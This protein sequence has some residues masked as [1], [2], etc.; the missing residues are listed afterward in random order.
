MKPQISP[1]RYA[2]VEMTNLFV[3]EELSSR[4]ERTRISCHAALETTA[5]AAFGK[6]S[7]MKLANATNTNRKSGAA[8]WRDLR[9]FST[10]PGSPGR[11]LERSDPGWCSYAMKLSSIHLPAAGNVQRVEILTPET[12]AG[13]L[14]I[15]G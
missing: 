2:P 6:E 4:P 8:E 11:K 15:A 7:R 3:Q 1:L 10:L 9:F 13:R 14:S 12:K 5:C